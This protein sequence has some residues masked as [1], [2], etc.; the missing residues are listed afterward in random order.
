MVT[1]TDSTLRANVFETIYDVVT[2]ISS[3]GLSSSNTVTVTAA[4]I[5]DERTLPQVVIHPV[6]IISGPASFSRELMHREIRVFIEV[7]SKKRKDLDQM[8]D[9]LMNA[10]ETTS[11]IGGM[12]LVNVDEST[13]MNAPLGLKIHSKAVGLTYTRMS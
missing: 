6:D 5:D 12:Q 10:I 4:Y 1:L 13:A 11:S 8:T 7:Y 3:W 2:G 9:A